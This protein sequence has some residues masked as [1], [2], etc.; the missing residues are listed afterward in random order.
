MEESA[1]IERSNEHPVAGRRLLTSLPG[2]LVLLLIGLIA[3]AVL[4]W[5]AL[6]WLL[7]RGDMPRFWSFGEDVLDEVSPQERASMIEARVMSSM[8]LVQLLTVFALILAGAAG[9]LNYR[10]AQQTFDHTRVQAEK[11]LSLARQG[12]VNERFTRA[13]DQLGAVTPGGTAAWETRLGGI[14]ALE[15]IAIDYPDEYYG[16]V[17]EVLTAYV[18]GHSQKSH[19]V[20]STAGEVATAPT[21]EIQAILTVIGR[22]NDDL[23]ARTDARINL[24]GADLRGAVLRGVNLRGADLIGARLDDVV[25]VEALLSG[26]SMT[27]AQLPGANLSRA[28]IQSTNLIKANLNGANLQWAHIDGAL[29]N[30]AQL[31]GANLIEARLCNTSMEGTRLRKAHLEGATATQAKLHNSDLSEAHLQGANLTGA[32]LEGVC[33]VGAHLE[34]A[35]LANA[36][37]EHADLRNA[38]L[39]GADVSGAVLSGANFEGTHL[40]GIIGLSQGEV[41]KCRLNHQTVLPEGFTHPALDQSDPDGERESVED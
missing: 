14:Y 2:W 6:P 30:D 1:T 27:S 4:I 36:R 26:A 39:E 16:P 34:G 20:G 31:E 40:A 11:Q 7:P 18:R 23:C 35:L 21:V 5:I 13:I 22:R 25:A 32:H 9:L 29:L 19:I 17:M 3:T 33:L 12:Q 41:N 38:H 24:R 15:R 10:Q 37:L 8:V 28:Q